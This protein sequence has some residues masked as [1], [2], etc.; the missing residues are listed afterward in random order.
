MFQYK[1]LNYVNYVLNLPYMD[2]FELYNKCIGRFNDMVL[3]KNDDRLWELFLF[4]VQ[5]GSF[6]GNYETY[7]DSKEQKQKDK[8]L[9]NE[10]AEKE[11]DRINKKVSKII[12]MDKRRNKENV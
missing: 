6:E 2:G 5:N 8:A 1:D 9:T 3:E 11:F 7:K 4:D 10:E 12:E